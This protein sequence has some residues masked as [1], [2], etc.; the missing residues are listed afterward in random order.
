MYHIITR[1]NDRIIMDSRTGKYFGGYDFMGS[2]DWYEN[3]VPA[4]IMDPDEDV[5]QI[6]KDLDAAEDPGDET[7]SKVR[8]GDVITD[9]SGTSF[10]VFKILYQDWYGS[11]ENAGISDCYGY[12]VEF[13]DDRNRY[14]HWKE[15]QDGGHVQR[16]CQYIEFWQDVYGATATI[17]RRCGRNQYGVLVREHWSVSVYTSNHAFVTAK[18]YD[19][20][21][22]ARIAMGKIGDD[23]KLIAHN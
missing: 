3:I 23:W 15:N 8:P 1:G 9:R 11:R 13:I 7:P 21:R 20:H 16:A 5:R 17:I 22:G 4:C 18:S 6:I 12:D 14:H 10:M 19:T 2:V